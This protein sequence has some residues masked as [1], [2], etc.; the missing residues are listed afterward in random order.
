LDIN[1]QYTTVRYDPMPVPLAFPDAVRRTARASPI[2]PKS[3]FISPSYNVNTAVWNCLR[4]DCYHNGGTTSN[5]NVP[6]IL[7]CPKGP[8]TL[9]EWTNLL[10]GRGT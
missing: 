9:Y 3:N 6:T 10:Y 1:A 5:A 8:S 4:R 7:W 2:A